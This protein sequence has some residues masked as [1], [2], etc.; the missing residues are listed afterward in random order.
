MNDRPLHREANR[1]IRQ[2]IFDDL[3][4]FEEFEERVNPIP[5]KKDRGDI[6]EI[7]IEGYLATQPITK[8]AQ[9]WVVGDVPLQI[10]E[11]FNL[12]NSS[13]GIDGI[14][15]TLSG[16]YIGYQV[17]YRRNHRLKWDDVTSFLAITDQ[18]TDRV[19]FT[20]ATVLESDA[21]ERTR[22]YSGD[23]FNALS[24]DE[25]KKIENWLRQKP[26][27]I[28]RATPD[29]NYQTQVLA[30]IKATLND[31]A[32][33]TVVMACGTGKTLVSLWA[34]E[35]E[36][37]KTVLV[38]LPSLLLLDATLKEWSQHTSW[39]EKFSYLCVCSDKKV[40]L[41]DD[42]LQID[43]SS[44]GFKVDTDPAVVRQFLE[45]P[46][47]SVKV[48]FSTYQSSQVVAEGCKG[49][50]PIDFAIFDEAHKT[51]GRAAKTFSYALDDENIQI[52]KRLFLTA[53]PR[54]IDIRKRDK[55]GEFQV[56]SMD[57]EKVY[58]PRAHTLSFGTAASK[59]II[60]D[61]K[62]LTSLID[63]EKVDDFA[64][65]NGIT[66]VE[67]DEIGADWVANLIALE[68][69]VKEV[70]VNKIIT[71]HSRVSNAEAFA[72]EGPQGINQYLPD[73]RVGHVNG[74][75]NTADRNAL[76]KAFA[77]APKGAITN[78]RCLTEGV[79]I[80]AVD[81]VAFIEPRQSKVDIVQAVGRAMRKP[82][83]K[84]TKTRGYVLVPLFAGTDG[85]GFDE[86][87]KSEK[88]DVIADV[89]N[90]LREHDEDLVDIIRGLKQ[91]KGSGKPF[92]PKRLAEKL[93]L[94]GPTV[95]L[96]ALF[97]SIALQI[98][99]TLGASWDEWFGK[100]TAYLLEND[101]PPQIEN[102]KKR[103]Q[104]GMT[105]ADWCSAQR[106]F[107]NKGSLSPERAK[108]LSALKGWSWD[109]VG[110]RMLVNAKAVR[111]WCDEN[112]TWMVPERGASFNGINI[113]AAAKSLKQ[114]FRAGLL[115][116][117]AQEE[118]EGIEGWTW[119]S[120]DEAVWN[121]K[122]EYYKNWHLANNAHMPPRDLWVNEIFGVP[123][124]NLG[125]WVNQQTARYTSKP[126][127]RSLSPDQI[128]RFE[129][130]IRFWAW[131]TWERAFLAYKEAKSTTS[132]IKS[133]YVNS[134]FP[135]EVQN[136]GRWQTKQ[137]EHC[138][139]NNFF[140]STKLEPK[141]LYELEKEGFCCDPFAISWHQGFLNL[142][143]HVE[144]NGTSKVEQ[145]FVSDDGFKLGQ[146]VSKQRMAR[147][148]DKSPDREF[149]YLL[150]SKL[151][152]WN[153]NWANS[154]TVNYQTASDQFIKDLLELTRDKD[155][156]HKAIKLALYAGLS[157]N[158][159]S[160]FDAKD[161][162]SG[163]FFEVPKQISKVN[164]RVIP[165]SETLID[166]RPITSTSY[167]ALAASLKRIKPAKYS[168]E[169]HFQSLSMRFA[170]E[171][172]NVGVPDTIIFM[173]N[174]GAPPEEWT[175]ERLKIL[176]EG[177]NSIKYA[178]ISN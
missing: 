158:E 162:D 152:D 176:T 151:P 173:V 18:M 171:L 155:D 78:A 95:E 62:V 144:V 79:N 94:I 116:E 15:A 71:F 146:W 114:S 83:G 17:K 61:Y 48:I 73:F 9:H 19:L 125:G 4:S 121:L 128:A 22:W 124:F 149:Q 40:G 35:Q 3:R 147:F 134:T 175:D 107:Y 20:N 90:A 52:T 91:A 174:N 154:R 167:G 24:A 58:G 130:E 6:F 55:D 75:Q 51:T 77:D 168:K 45:Q 29:P 148:A 143:K 49:L 166:T 25:L 99:D 105:L 43:P 126:G 44:V 76:I 69:A 68:Q 111:N 64:R 5:L 80:P 66:L 67:G 138:Q 136:V 101:Y 36:K 153:E 72:S 70:G 7:F 10:R 97:E 12:P 100:L 142:R 120:Q 81:M 161:L 60:C 82:R 145:S 96:E 14:Y 113:S 89:L 21:K 140:T 56:R 53:T 112:K 127:V 26:V 177:V 103:T 165:I 160:L 129:S 16:E 172:K 178:F 65:K 34:T 47:D 98:T 13:K 141:F 23:I 50:P 63:K 119:G 104:T 59:G 110:Q 117:K 132:E 170:E 106:T 137:R 42:A 8:H 85:K 164:Y 123:P 163:R 37:P 135:K 115:G 86:A 109:P 108:R 169:M 84:T 57:D 2:G 131:H 32:R 118:I 102:K 93:E 74:S 1:W 150:L 41:K 88:F 28:K 54:H 92:N 87:I 122:F 159:V 33:A 157:L 31:N 39:G 139:T 46:S 11:L 30:D 156:L 133:S 27:P 38:L